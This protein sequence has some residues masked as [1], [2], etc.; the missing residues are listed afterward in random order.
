MTN[1]LLLVTAY[2]HCA[3]CNGVSGNPTASGVMPKPGITVAASRS[4]PFGTMVLIDGIGWRRVEDRLAVRYDSRIDVFM[5]THREA[6]RFGS[7][8]KK[9]KI[10]K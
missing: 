6:K 3:L 4:I 1:L 5:R 7:Q 2:C 8:W 9:V 10:M